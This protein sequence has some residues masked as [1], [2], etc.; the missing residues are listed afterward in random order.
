M[1]VCMC[2]CVSVCKHGAIKYIYTYKQRERGAGTLDE[3]L[4]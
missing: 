4:K 3:D 1:G 2:V